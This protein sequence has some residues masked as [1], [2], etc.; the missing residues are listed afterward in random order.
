MYPVS[1]FLSN[2]V[3]LMRYLIILATLLVATV[4]MA[5]TSGTHKKKSAYRSAA[6]PP[7]REFRGAWIQC[8]N[9]QWTG[10]GRDAMQSTLVRQLD[11]LKRCGINA[12]MFQVRAEADAL[13]RSPYEPWSRYLTA[14]QGRVPEPFW[15]PLAWMVEECHRR[16][17]ECHAWINPFRAKTKG[18][19]ALAS[20]HPYLRHPER[21]FHYDGLIVFDPG[22]QENRDYICEV[23][24]DIVS[25]YDV[26]GLH[27]DDYFYP[28][29][30]GGLPIPDDATYARYGNGMSRGD[31]RR[32]NVNK[33]VK[34]LNETVKAVKPWCKFGVSPFGIYRNKRND[35][36]GSETNGLQNYDDLY[37]D[38]L[39]WVRQGWVD[40]NIPQIYWQIGH[41]TADY[42]TLIRWWSDNAGARH[43]YIGQDVERTV[44]YPDLRNPNTHQ[45]NAK[46]T[47]QRTLHG[48]EGSCQWYAKAVVDNVGNYGTMLKQNYHKHPA[49]APLMPWIDQKPP[50]KIRRPDII[51][52]SDGPTLMWTAPKA[53]APLDVAAWYAVYRFRKG[54]EIDLDDA[55]HL[56]AVTRNT[57]YNL[58]ADA[59]GH[60]YVVTAL[61]HMHNESKGRKIK[62]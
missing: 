7:K 49:L 15:D 43:L 46:Y 6:I 31:W 36:R 52:T 41:P 21:F 16:G 27:I 22:L 1:C 35:P 59:P 25:R 3:L 55:A 53:K 29:P 13:Y 17:M 62:L 57:F 2:F 12:V 10:M 33:F 18:T 5:E 39:E 58:P 20:N 51:A 47:L 44:K 45:M 60:V 23:A 56:V 28:Y 61:D 37:A 40:Y 8:V 30:A 14:E 19:N 54:E 38:V 11:E 4:G 42:E 34:Q 24:R 48:V 32:S 50:K 26:D 9:N